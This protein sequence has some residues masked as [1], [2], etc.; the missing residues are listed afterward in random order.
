MERGTTTVLVLL[1]LTIGIGALICAG[2][3]YAAFFTAA[4]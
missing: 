4:V 2:L 1:L 3:W